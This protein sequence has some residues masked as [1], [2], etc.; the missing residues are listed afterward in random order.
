MRVRAILGRTIALTGDLEAG[1][2]DLQEAV[3]IS[4]QLLKVDPNHSEFQEYAALYSSQLSRLHRLD[5][6]FA[7]GEFDQCACADRFSELT[8]QDPANSLWQ[9]ESAEAQ[10]ERAAQL[11]AAGQRDAA[12]A[13]ARDALKVLDPL[14]ANRPDGR[15]ILLATTNA[16]LLLA[17]ATDDASQS[18]QLRSSVLDALHAGRGAGSDPRLLAVEVP[19][20]IGL[21]RTAETKPLVERLWAS[22]Y[23]DRAL[24]ALLQRAHIDYPVNTEFQQRLQ[25]AVRRNGQ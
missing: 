17:D 16:R 19:A 4:E 13:Q 9:Q 5:R 8:R 25:A 18:E 3:D 24:S 20:L 15:S 7:R 14:L 22:G 23:R 6:R 11:L 10:T 2:K 1:M 12:R 21:G